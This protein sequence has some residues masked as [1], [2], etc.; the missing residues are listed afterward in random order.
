[1]RSGGGGGVAGGVAG[2]APFEAATGDG[3]EPVDAGLRQEEVRTAFA[4]LLQI[5][6]VTGAEGPAVW[7]REQPLRAV[8]L[9]LEASGVPPSAVDPETGRRTAAGYR[10]GPGE[11]PGLVRVTWAGPPGS[12]A[13]VEEAERLA[14][15]ADVLEGLGWQAL[16]YR[17]PGR[18][19]F[20]E[21][22]PPPGGA[23]L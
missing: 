8:S 22:E 14:G 9:A 15:C 2:G 12:R 18:R 23:S 5:R 1:M 6:R 20:L 17:G 10:T 7:E 21:V 3:P 13:P 11:A 4:G 19:R 16:L